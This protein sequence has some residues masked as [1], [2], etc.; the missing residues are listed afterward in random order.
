MEDLIRQAEAALHAQDGK[1]ALALAD[2]MLARDET[3]CRAW[4][5]ALQSFQL[6]LPIEQYD[7]ANEIN[8]AKYAI[9]FAPREEKGA[10]RKQVYAFLL[11]KVIEVLARDAEVLSDGRELIGFY[12]RTVYFDASG[13]AEKTREHDRATFD[14]VNRSFAYCV[15]L[16]ESIPATAIRRS[17]PLNR[18]AEEAAAQWQKTYSYLA[19]R[20]G[21]Y[22][23]EMTPDAIR[24][25][26]RIYGR[27]LR[28]VR[29]AEAI[30][31]KPVPFNTTGEDQTAY[32]SQGNI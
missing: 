32:L 17:A 30:I 29:N 6:F 26:L 27:F 20:I 19:L 5:I 11:G 14:A 13:A 7:P 21:L 9:R 3:C 24:Y 23:R 4:L 2:E 28:D 31:A 8:C 12:Q 15:A 16:F 10:V 22:H 1:A 25:G 18:K